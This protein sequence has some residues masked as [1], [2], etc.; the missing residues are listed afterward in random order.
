MCSSLL[1]KAV[2]M[3]QQFMATQ[4]V[5]DTVHND[6]NGCYIFMKAICALQVIKYTANETSVNTIS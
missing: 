1:V 6:G 5:D 4:L 3:S 2:C